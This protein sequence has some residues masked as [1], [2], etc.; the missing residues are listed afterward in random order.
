MEKQ[1][2]IRRGL[3][4]PENAEAVKQAAAGQRVDLTSIR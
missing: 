4:P 3:T 1:G 2:E